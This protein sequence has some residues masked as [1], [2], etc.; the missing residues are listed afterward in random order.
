MKLRSRIPALLLA[1]LCGLTA[2]LFAAPQAASP[3][4]WRAYQDQAVSLLQQYLRI[5]TSNPPGNELQ[6]ARFFQKLFDQA[7]ISNTVF[8][9][10]PGRANIYAVIH[11]DGALRPLV[12]LNHMDVVRAQPQNWRVPPFSAE[13]LNGELYGRGA[14]DMKD[15]GLMQAVV[16]LAAARQRPP[17]KRD[18]IFLATA[19]EEVNDTGSAWMIHNHPELVKNAEYLIT[20]GGDNLILP[21]GHTIYGIDVAEKAPYWVRLTAR[22]R[23]GHGSIP[24]ADSAPNQLVKALNRVV[25]WQT[26]IHLL[27]SVEEYFHQI[28]SL[29]PEPLASQYR[30]VRQALKD[31]AFVQKV[32]ADENLN[33]RL[34][35]TVSLTM[36]KGSEQTN[37]IPD[38]AYAQLDVRLLPGD[39]P[40]QFEAELRKVVDDPKVSID[41]ITDYRTP[42]SSS[43]HTTL[44]G[45]MEDEVH[46]Y[47][48]RAVVAPVLDSGYTESQMYRTLGIQCYGFVPIEVTPELDATEHAA[49]E[50]VPVEQIRRGVKM[51][52]EVVTR[53]GVQP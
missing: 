43:T 35:D 14:E 52:Y 51:L 15:E 5:N 27:P 40:R 46:R 10:L 34:R 25:R 23:G 1:L 19:D 3:V 48:P 9:Y 24:I 38:T 11:G 31:P 30:N 45:I 32:T 12:M 21:D 42:N 39:D 29:Q 22:A 50:R 28:A 26:P 2:R 13:I 16:M 6:T 37:V 47:N 49:N 8:E 18:L 36:L 4:D 44:Y 33:Y 53:I 17:L 7:G 41:P 20:E